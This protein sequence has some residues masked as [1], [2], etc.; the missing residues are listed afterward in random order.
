MFGAVVLLPCLFVCV[1]PVIVNWLSSSTVPHLVHCQLTMT[2][3]RSLL[4]KIHVIMVY[5][6]VQFQLWCLAKLP[7]GWVVCW[8][9]QVQPGVVFEN[10][11][12]TQPCH[13][14][15]QSFMC[16]FTHALHTCGLQAKITWTS[17]KQCMCCYI[18]NAASC[19]NQL[20][21]L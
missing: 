20:V 5:R 18:R 4:V 10:Q 6:H 17:H 3:L 2:S 19:I 7:Y 14:H 11:L 16:S 12:F 1:P 8:A 15:L 9:V 21:V 13:G